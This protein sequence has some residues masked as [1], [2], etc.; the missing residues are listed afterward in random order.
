MWDRGLHSYAMV[1]ATR[2]QGCDYLGRI[3]KN[4]KCSVEL[5]LDDGSY[6]RSDCSRRQVQEKR[7]WFDS[8]A[9]G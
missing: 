4:V 7:L 8:G 5:V 2:A 9:S 6:L 3:P 1:N